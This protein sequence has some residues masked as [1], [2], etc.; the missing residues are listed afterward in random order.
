MKSTKLKHIKSKELW[1]KFIEIHE[2]TMEVKLEGS[3]LLRT[4][5]NNLKLEKE[6]KLSS[7][8]ARIKEIQNGL[9]SI[10]ETISNQ[11]M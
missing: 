9:T 10:G 4:Q 8:H 3:D 11:D 7:L 2:G 5:F 1:E 6:K